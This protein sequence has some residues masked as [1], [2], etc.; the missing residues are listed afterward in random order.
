MNPVPVSADGLLLREW[1]AADR[2]QIEAAARDPDQRLWNP[3]TKPSD[4][5]IAD[6][7]DWSDGT[8]A[9]WAVVLPDD[10]GEVLGSV[11]LHQIDIANAASEIGYWV[12]ADRRGRGIAAR[13]VDAATTFGFD[14]LDLRRVFLFHAVENLGSCRVA[15]KA[16]FQLEGTHR[17]S[18]RCGDGELHD[19]HSHARLVTDAAPPRRS[20]TP[21]ADR[22]SAR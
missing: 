17:Q 6:R 5:W 7:T 3:M 22:G 8:H 11:S 20:P 1:R 21:R 10:P 16:G 15:E 2:D 13:A 19:E 12:R 14:Q 4:E 18:Y 9:S